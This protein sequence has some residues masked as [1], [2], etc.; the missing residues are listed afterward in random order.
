M[1]EGNATTKGSTDAMDIKRAKEIVKEYESS[2]GFSTH[3]AFSD[4][5]GESKG[6]L[7]HAEQTRPLIDAIEKRLE[8][9]CNE[10]GPCEGENCYCGHYGLKGSLIQY[11]ASVN[12]P[13]SN[14]G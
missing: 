11:K 4:R 7:L 1:T 10:T 9:G 12:N 3:N 13:P 14:E 6:Y 8:A 5:Y 2:C